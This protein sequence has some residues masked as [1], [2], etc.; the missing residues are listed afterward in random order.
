MES[1]YCK[2]DCGN[3]T[4]CKDANGNI[5]KYICT[6]NIKRVTS[7]NKRGK[8]TIKKVY[9]EL[10]IEDGQPMKTAICLRGER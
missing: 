9:T 5:V 3:L 7:F 10:E 6:M 2:N 1:P 8:P 4:P